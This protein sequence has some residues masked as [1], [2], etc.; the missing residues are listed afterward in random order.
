MSVIVIGYVGT[1]VGSGM[2]VAV[3]GV[4]VVVVCEDSET[5]DAVSSA[6]KFEQPTS[7]R[8]IML[9]VISEILKLLYTC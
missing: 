2:G 3:A 9:V 1:V 4:W 5:M 7:I 6:I 8:A